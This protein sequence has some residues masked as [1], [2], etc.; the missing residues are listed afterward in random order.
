MGVNGL[1]GEQ[2]TS[3]VLLGGDRRGALGFKGINEDEDMIPSPNLFGEVI[4]L[5]PPNLSLR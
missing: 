5:G 1:V 4:T 2:G 3:N